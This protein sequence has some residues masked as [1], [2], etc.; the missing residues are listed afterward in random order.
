M[1]VKFG[2]VF[3]SVSEHQITTF[4]NPS[5][6]AFFE[7]DLEKALDSEVKKGVFRL[8]ENRFDTAY[9]AKK[10]DVLVEKSHR[11]FTVF[12]GVIA[13][14]KSIGLVSGQ[15][16]ISGSID[17]NTGCKI[18]IEMET[19]EGKQASTFEQSWIARFNQKATDRANKVLQE[20][21]DRRAN[22]DEYIKQ[23]AVAAYTEEDTCAPTDV[24]V[25]RD[26]RANT[27]E[28]IKQQA[29]AACTKED[30]CTPRDFKVKMWRVEKL[31]SGKVKI[32]YGVKHGLFSEN[33]K[34]PEEAE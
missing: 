28:Y 11:Y 32:Q 2:V 30:T 7:P 9:D 22:V 34:K 27:G 25:I 10:Y 5:A 33:N 29:A 21:Q 16:H 1:F 13:H 31:E 15:F 26:G 24:E 23:Q 3:M 18:K 14:A 6:D 19:V 12:N 17:P 8:G 20:I 4:L